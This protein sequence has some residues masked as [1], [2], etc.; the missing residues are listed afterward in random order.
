MLQI[1]AGIFSGRS[2][3][4]WVVADEAEARATLSEIVKDRGLLADTAPAAAG[5]GFRG[6]WIDVLSDELTQDFGLGTN[7]YLGAI[8]VQRRS[9]PRHRYRVPI[10]SRPRSDTLLSYARSSIIRLLGTQ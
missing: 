7:V 4:T 5:L 2:N 3:P 9:T 1:T 10:P 6:L 8:R